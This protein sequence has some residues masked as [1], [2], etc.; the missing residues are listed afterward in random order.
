MES[1]LFDLEHFENQP[2]ASD[3]VCAICR[4]VCR[5][6]RQNA[7]EDCGHLFCAV[8]VTDLAKFHNDT[9]D[10]TN[11]CIV[12]PVCRVEMSNLVPDRNAALKIGKLKVICPFTRDKC[13]WTGEFG[14]EGKHLL[15]HWQ[16]D[17]IASPAVCPNV[18]CG[19]QFA[20]HTL[21]LHLDACAH[22]SISCPDCCQS[23]SWGSFAVHPMICP[24]RLVTCPNGCGALCRQ[25]IVAL[26]VSNLCDLA[27]APCPYAS[28]GCTEHVNKS[29]REQH[30]QDRVSG[31]LHMRLILS[32]VQLLRSENAAL[33]SQI[34]ALE[35]TVKSLRDVCGEP[36][37]LGRAQRRNPMSVSE[38]LRPF[39]DV[40]HQAASD[41]I[42][43]PFDRSPL[44]DTSSAAL[45]EEVFAVSPRVCVCINDDGLICGLV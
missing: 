45:S 12:C 33:R 27:V 23:M 39:C 21:G 7:S 25:R 29:N 16:T 22:R 17:C 9:A 2:A 28:V 37:I 14:L 36:R 32:Q 8:C 30:E 42:A 24:D 3:Y 34:Q 44:A 43:T 13:A 41:R 4:G 20:K 35:Q 10:R 31:A 5:S 40:L 6:A 1:A 18:G 19:K 11:A 26:H 38:P 15:S